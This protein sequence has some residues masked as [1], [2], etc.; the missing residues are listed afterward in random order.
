M[1]QRFAKASISKESNVFSKKKVFDINQKPIFCK[2][3][4]CDCLEPCNYTVDE[5]LNVLSPGILKEE[6]KKHNHPVIRKVYKKALPIIKNREELVKHYEFVHANNDTLTDII[7]DSTKYCICKKVYNIEKDGD[8]IMC[9]N[10]TCEV[11]WFHLSC[12][13]LEM[14]QNLENGR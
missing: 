5:I 13:G 6:L 9:D 2:E 12:V 1:R 11:Q 3:K 14:T 4:C 8:M 10:E 7:E